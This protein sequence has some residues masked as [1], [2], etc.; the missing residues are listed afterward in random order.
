MEPWLPE[1]P[2][3]RKGDITLSFSRFLPFSKLSGLMAVN[4]APFKNT[5]GLADLSIPPFLYHRRQ[6]VTVLHI[7]PIPQARF[8]SPPVQLQL[9]Q[10]YRRDCSTDSIRLF[11]K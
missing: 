10:E 8:L 4:K 7:P 9:F 1:T 3:R 6:I 5:H 2:P 11:R